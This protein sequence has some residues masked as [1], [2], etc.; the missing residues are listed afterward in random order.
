MCN[1]IKSRGEEKKVR[2][3]PWRKVRNLEGWPASP[4]S[5]SS[6]YFSRTESFR[7]SLSL[8]GEMKNGFLSGLLRNFSFEWT[9]KLSGHPIESRRGVVGIS[10]NSSNENN[11]LW[12]Y[13]K[14]IESFLQG[15]KPFI[16]CNRISALIGARVI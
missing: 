2:P 15:I 4:S 11:A 1:E 13:S 10:R 8:A 14:S 7:R 16:D 9:Y 5:S 3:S 12:G 6:L